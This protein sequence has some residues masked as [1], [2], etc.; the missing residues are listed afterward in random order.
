MKHTNKV[1]SYLSI[2]VDGI[3]YHANYFALQR[4]TNFT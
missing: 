4:L 3:F 1:A 2:K